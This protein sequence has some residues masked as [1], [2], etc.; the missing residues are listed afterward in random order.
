RFD[1]VHAIRDERPTHFLY[2]IARRV[3]EALSDREVHLV[4]ENDANQA[5]YLARGSRGRALFHTAQ[6]NDDLHHSWHVL[7][8]GETEGYYAD[9]ARDTISHLGRALAEGFA[10]Q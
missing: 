6:W 7:L 2:D 5:R 9:Y 4:L 3:R 10:Y 8:S 1:A